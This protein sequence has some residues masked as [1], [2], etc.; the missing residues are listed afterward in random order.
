MLWIGVPS[1]RSCRPAW[2][3]DT[4]QLLIL[5]SSCSW[6]A[7][8]DREGLMSQRHLV[9]GGAGFVGSHL[10]RLMERG[11]VICLITTSQD[12]KTIFVMD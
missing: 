3:F 4:E 11:D 2:L 8:L 6:F 12:A 7:S 10:D 1:R 5:G 9:T